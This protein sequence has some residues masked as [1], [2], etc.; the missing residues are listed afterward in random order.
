MPLGAAEQGG[1]LADVTALRRQQQAPVL[2]RHEHDAGPAAQHEEVLHR[3][4][5]AR[6]V[7]VHCPHRGLMPMLSMEDICM[8]EHIRHGNSVS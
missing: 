5:I 6:R 8:A 2:H 4:R 3:N 1:S 7:E